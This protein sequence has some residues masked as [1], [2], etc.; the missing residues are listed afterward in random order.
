M[1]WTAHATHPNG[2]HRLPAT[3][4]D[5]QFELMDPEIRDTFHRARDRALAKVEEV[6]AELYCGGLCLNGS[7]RVLSLLSGHGGSLTSLDTFSPPDVFNLLHAVD[8]LDFEFVT[9]EL[10]L[11]GFDAENDP[12][13]TYFWSATEF[14]RACASAQVG[15]ECDR[16]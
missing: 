12:F 15:F 9:K 10:V 13:L 14:V 2:G 1:S 4:V 11:M 8:M 16:D 5:G 7:G 3:L 6:D